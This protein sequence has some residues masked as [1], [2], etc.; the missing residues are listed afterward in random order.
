[1]WP[2]S[3]VINWN[4]MVTNLIGLF[5]V[6]D[7]SSDTLIQMNVHIMEKKVI[8]ESYEFSIDALKVAHAVA[9]DRFPETFLFGAASSAYQIEGAYK[10]LGNGLLFY[11]HEIH[12][13]PD[14]NLLVI[15]RTIEVLSYRYIEKGMNVW[16]YWTHLEPDLIMD[17]SNGDIACHSFYKY[18]EDIEMLKNLGVRR[19]FSS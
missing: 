18:P 16:D 6:S 15:D 1:M 9:Q 4:I 12:S 5:Y 19:F 7:Y 17:N 10:S 13:E 14:S 8:A 3:Q 2:L 11:V